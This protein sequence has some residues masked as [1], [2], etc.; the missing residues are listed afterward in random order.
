MSKPEL[1][2]DASGCRIYRADQQ[3]IVKRSA[4][5]W[6]SIFK[7]IT[8]IL[9]LIPI[10]GGL[11]FMVN[12]FSGK[13][14]LL[15]PAVIL[16]LMAF[17]F[18]MLFWVSIRLERRRKERS[19]TELDTICIFDEPSG[20]LLDKSSAELAHIADVKIKRAFQMTSSSKKLIAEWPNGSLVIA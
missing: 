1:F 4:P 12:W 16:L 3:I 2:V 7:F 11:T 5:S 17:V 20:K 6:I 19:F 14:D 18:S 15:V 10:G 8:L 9:M 13:H